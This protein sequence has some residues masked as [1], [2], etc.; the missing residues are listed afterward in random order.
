MSIP[1]ATPELRWHDVHD[2]S[3]Y[4]T[5]EDGE[6]IQTALLTAGVVYVGSRPRNVLYRQN[7]AIGH[8]NERPM[9]VMERDSAERRYLRHV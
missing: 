2:R 1:Q 5:S 9:L 3:S 6:T 4:E 7:V 8:R